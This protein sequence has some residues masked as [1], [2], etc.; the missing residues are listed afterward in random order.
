[1]SPYFGLDS[2]RPSAAREAT[3][4]LAAKV[5]NTPGGDIDAAETFLRQLAEPITALSKVVGE[6]RQD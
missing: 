1:M 4:A 6:G 3:D 2:A 5:G